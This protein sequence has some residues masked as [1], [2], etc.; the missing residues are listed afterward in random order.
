MNQGAVILALAAAFVVL[1]LV[2]LAMCI[3]QRDFE[4]RTKE[5]FQELQK[6]I[7]EGAAPNGT[8]GV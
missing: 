3:R 5:A 2:L 7:K 4:E 6:V 8:K 1:A